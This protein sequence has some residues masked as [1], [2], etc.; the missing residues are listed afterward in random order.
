MSGARMSKAVPAAG[1]EA[2]SASTPGTTSSSTLSALRVAVER[3]ENSH[4]E[5]LSPRVALG[6]SEA[7]VA[8]KGGLALGSL[9]EV[10]AGKGHS[11]AATGFVAGLARLATQ[12]KR[13]VLWVRQDFA[14]REAGELAME[15]FAELGLD[16]RYL[17]VVRAASAQSVLAITADGLAC[18]A[19][20]AVVSEM[21]G[22]TK[23]FDLVA[24]RKLTL[25]AGT[26]GVTN[27]MLRFAAE[28][29]ASTAETRWIVR[30]AHSPP[31]AAE[32][33]WG[34]P[35]FD[36]ELARNRHGPSGRW[37]MEWTCDEYLFRQRELDRRKSGHAPHSQ[38]A[39]AAPADRS[40]PAA[41]ATRARRHA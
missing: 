5:R 20:G 30:A 1:G 16:P 26:S 19:L 23:A 40:Y 12:G 9:H 31:V 21:W 6:H 29:C 2:G 34:V 36:A 38:S 13:F 10:F 28:P 27:L 32:D 35:A 3:L 15:G 7:D 39:I 4:P 25:A 8:L 41:A 17:I 11:A 18:N 22:E 14:A 33:A 37:I 24:S